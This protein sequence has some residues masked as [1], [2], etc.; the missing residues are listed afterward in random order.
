M[1]PSS[2]HLSFIAQVE[3]ES[4]MTQTKNPI[5]CPD[6]HLVDLL[7]LLLFDSRVLPLQGVDICGHSFHHHAVEC[8]MIFTATGSDRSRTQFCNVV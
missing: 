8:S 1:T 6:V 3:I 4:K 2:D 5:T 7:L